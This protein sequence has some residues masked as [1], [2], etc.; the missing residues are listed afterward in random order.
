MLNKRTTPES[1]C[2]SFGHKFLPVFDVT[3][4]SNGQKLNG[5]W[6]CPQ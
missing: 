1:C 6:K 4:P 5:S 2:G 3:I